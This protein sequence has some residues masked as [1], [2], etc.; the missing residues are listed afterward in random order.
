MNLRIL[1]PRFVRMTLETDLDF[2][3]A[4]GPAIALGPAVRLSLD[5]A[6]DRTTVVGT[7]DFLVITDQL[8][9]Y[10][11]QLCQ[12]RRRAKS[13]MSR[14]NAVDWNALLN[15]ARWKIVYKALS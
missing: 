14:P 1:H 9:N 2:A 13:C 3:I 12:V 6:Q 7:E 10:K 4:P 15:D 8:Q 5:A 11:A